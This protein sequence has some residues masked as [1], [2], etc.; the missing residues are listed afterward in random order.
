MPPIII[1]ESKVDRK[2]RF[3]RLM[4]DNNWTK[5]ELARHLGV[6]RACVSKVLNN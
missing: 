3:I 1:K 2:K 5:A 4:K 6:S